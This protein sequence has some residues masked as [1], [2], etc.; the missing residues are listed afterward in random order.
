MDYSTTAPAFLRLLAIMAKLRSPEGCPWDAE[1]T[2]QSLKPYL[3]EETHEV[4]EA[5]DNEEPAAVC[6]ELG[7]LLLQIV[8]QARIFEERGDFA[9]QNVID[10]IAEKLI[11][12]HPHVFAEAACLTPEEVS[13]QWDRI[14]SGEKVLKGQSDS[15]LGQVPDTA[16]SAAGQQVD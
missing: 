7:D 10:G 13:R 5:I 11:R 4:L 14:K 9:M 12:R 15:V 1:Q 6:E 16:G 2:P 3:L 8:F